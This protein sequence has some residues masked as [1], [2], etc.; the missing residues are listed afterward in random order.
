MTTQTLQNYAIQCGYDH[1]NDS[2]IIH[3][4]V[5]V[6]LPILNLHFNIEN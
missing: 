1:F 3:V 4:Y 2:N 5:K 6:H